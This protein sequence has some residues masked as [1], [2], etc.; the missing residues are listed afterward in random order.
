MQAFCLFCRLRDLMS[1][2]ICFRSHFCILSPT[3]APTNA[4]TRTLAAP[5]PQRHAKTAALSRAESTTL[6][7]ATCKRCQRHKLDRK[8]PDRRPYT[9]L[10]GY[11]LPCEMQRAPNISWKMR[12]NDRKQDTCT[13]QARKP[14]PDMKVSADMDTV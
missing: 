5:L 7:T 3:S 12:V 14:T 9:P 11:L 8:L 1:M 13:P 6:R 4:R 2:M 10:R